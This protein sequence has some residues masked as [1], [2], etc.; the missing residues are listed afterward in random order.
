MSFQ[1]LSLLGTIVNS[2]DALTKATLYYNYQP[3]A[4]RMSQEYFTMQ[5]SDG[6]GEVF[7][8]TFYIDDL[9]KYPQMLMTATN[10]LK[11]KI[12]IQSLGNNDF[13]FIK[14]VSPRD[15]YNNL[16]DERDQKAVAFIF[17]LDM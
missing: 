16:T 6:D 4:M 9:D 1:E 2:I 5:D 15:Y 7:G 12:E 8:H 14:A 3:W 11:K 17:R 13:P 10:D